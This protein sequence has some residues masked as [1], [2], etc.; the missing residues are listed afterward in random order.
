MKNR[1]SIIITAIIVLVIG[2]LLVYVNNVFLPMMFKAKITQVL[3]KRLDKNVRIGKLRYNFFQ[4]LKIQ[5]LAIFSKSKKLYVEAKEVSLNFL[6]LPLFQTNIIIPHVSLRDERAVPPYVKEITDLKIET[7]TS[8]FNQIYFDLN[9][10]ILNPLPSPSLISATGSCNIRK[11][12]LESWVTLSNIIVNDY[13]L[14]LKNIPF[15]VSNGTMD[16]ELEVNFK[17]KRL[18]LRGIAKIKDANLIK[19]EFALSGDI[20]LE[21]DIK[22]DFQKKR[23]DYKGCLGLSDGTLSGLGY[24]QDISKLRGN[25]CFEEN[26]I[27]S[28]NLKANVLDSPIYIKGN[29][30]LSRDEL[31]WQNIT[32]AYRRFRVNST[33]K[34]NIADLRQPVINLQLNAKDLS[35]RTNFAVSVR[36]KVVNI[37]SCSGRYLNYGFALKGK[38]GAEDASLDL[39]IELNIPLKGAIGRLPAKM[40]T[41]LKRIKTDRDFSG[42]L[43]AKLNM[44]ANLQNFL[45]TLE[46]KG[47]AY[48][49]EANFWALNLFSGLAEYLS[50]PNYHKIVFKQAEGNFI[51]QD[52]YIYIMNSSLEAEGVKVS[53]QGKIGFN[54]RPNLMLYANISEDLI[55]EVL[56]F[57]EA[58]S[59]L[60]VGVSKIHIFGSLKTPQYEFVPPD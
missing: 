44:R 30:D 11:R 28:N 50:I 2:A 40:G 13:P 4:G 6:I 19:N 24:L 39:E 53:C 42:K 33:G 5:D 26:K 41:N 7:K 20:V 54:G 47:F 51:I 58:T 57:K 49:K 8:L 38:V 32:V 3:E 16:A 31:N 9:A 12:R 15:S 10:Q 35:L 27:W 22:Y 56:N 14:Y 55:K 48:V 60:N 25:I 29:I 34:I 37:R 18:S 52:K 36:D 45:E 17:K 59:L 46:A 43:N 1:T 21:P 23:L